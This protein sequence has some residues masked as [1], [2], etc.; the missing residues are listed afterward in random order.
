MHYTCNINEEE[1]IR[2]IL[3]TMLVSLTWYSLTLYHED[4]SMSLDML[5]TQDFLMTAEN[6]II[7]VYHHLT[8]HVLNYLIY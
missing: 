5:W 4:F 7:S 1:A 8:W 3:K 2:I 6:I